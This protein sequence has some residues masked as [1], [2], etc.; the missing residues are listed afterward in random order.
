MCANTDQK[1]ISVYDSRG[2]LLI[3]YPLGYRPWG[4]Y[5]SPD[6]YMYVSHDDEKEITVYTLTMKNINGVK[7]I[8]TV[9]FPR[10]INMVGGNMLVQFHPG[11]ISSMTF[12]G[13]NIRKICKCGGYSGLA[14]NVTSKE[15]RFYY[16]GE[17]AVV[18]RSHD[19]K[20]VFRHILE[21]IYQPR[22]VALD[23]AENVYACGEDSNKIFV[24]SKD[25]SS[26]RVLLSDLKPYA[27]GFDKAGTRFF[28]SDKNNKTL[29]VYKLT[30]K[31]NH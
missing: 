31:N 8:K 7:C 5:L 30:L 18:C 25:G 9:N 27:I 10:T 11:F 29:A 4:V 22:G 23:A 14:V 19:G 21:D 24:I 15:S 20:E 13:V 2:Q 1:N 6:G 28:V 12:D 16:S 26:S 17:K 3:T